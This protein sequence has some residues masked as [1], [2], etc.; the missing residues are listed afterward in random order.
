MAK[1]HSLSIKNFRGIKDFSHIFNKS[2]F[3]CLIGRGDSGKTTILEAISYVLY[4]NWNL[5][6]FDSD[7]Y[8]CEVEN[9]IEIE[10]SL[11]DLPD[12][13]LSEDKFGLYKRTLNPITK[14]V[15]DEISEESENDVLSIKLIVDK[16]LE[17]K[18]YVF[19]GRDIEIQI[20]HYDRA[21]LNVY[22][23]SD[24][25]DRH[26]SWNKGN[27]LY[28]LL[29][30][31]D[32]V[33]GNENKNTIIDAIRSIKSEID[34]KSSFEQFLNTTN[35]IKSQTKILGVDISN[36]NTSIDLKDIAVKDGKV[37]LHDED[38]K[39][40][41]RLKGK[42]TKRLIS[43]AIQMALAEENGIVLI[44]EI[45]QGLEPDR[46]QHLVNILKK[47]FKGQIFI[48]THSRNVIT[49]LFYDNLFLLKKGA[50]ELTILNKDIQGCLRTNPEVFFSGKIIV[51]EGATEVGICRALNTFRMGKYENCA[52]FL[53]VSFADGH[54]STIVEYCKELTRIGYKVCLFC[55]SDIKDK[56]GINDKKEE[57]KR[58]GVYI[59]D[60][61]KGEYT[62]F[63]IIN[64]IP[65]EILVEILNLVVDLI[66]V[67][68]KPQINK[69]EIKARVYETI[70]SK[71]VGV[72]PVKINPETITPELR[73]AISEASIVKKKEWF[74][75]ISR[76][77]KLGDL[78]FKY[79]DKLL[80]NELKQNL[81]KLSDWIDDGIR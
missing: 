78:I 6:F 55:D 44:D 64:N 79:Y 38:E 20:S 61:N 71:N 22:M 50:T 8:K 43:L 68:E 65:S 62:E 34:A 77:E 53:G 37:S 70:K 76:G 45:E 9:N 21:K 24:Y 19:N 49:E 52:T 74:K 39:I 18:W 10:V 75:S 59:I 12:E 54:G 63:A 31:E 48:T 30:R 35:K 23:I 47:N 42:G 72:T 36:I 17:P 2:N 16:Y 7:F 67:Y 27:P 56:H 69:N 3:I 13:L 15:M 80:D 58:I 40:P 66:E 26:F 57:L 11:L 29:K 81:D 28:S 51:C 32:V 41:F 5:T 46:V 25:I 73:N 60:W 33:S 14:E 4:P 1:I